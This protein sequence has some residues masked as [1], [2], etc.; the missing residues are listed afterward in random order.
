LTLSSDLIDIDEKSV[1]EDSMKRFSLVLWAALLF[2]TTSTAFA[3]PGLSVY[4]VVN[5]QEAQLFADLFKKETGIEVQF[6]RAATGDLLN[7]VAAEKSAP[8]ADILLGG[9]STLHLGLAAKGVLAVYKSPVAAT[10]PDYAQDPDGHWTGFYITTLGIGVNETRFKQKFGNTP[11]PK[12][13]DDLVNP[14]FKGEIVLTDP[15]ASSTAYLFVQTQLQRLGWD[16]GWAYLGKLAPLVGQFPSSGGAPPQLVGS[17]EYSIGVA[18]V[19]ALADYKA[20]GFPIQLI[21]PPK[22]SGEI[23]AVSIIAGGP[24][25]ANA[26]KF[27]DFVLS[28]AAQQAFVNLSLTTPLNPAVSAPSTGVNSKTL[29]LQKFDAALAATQR[30]AVLA[31]WQ[32]VVK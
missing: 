8:Q 20:K 13:W 28:P 19:H 29:D 32:K 14:A 7:R 9:A 25:P 26:K 27:V 5:Q 16:A 10:L 15:A 31:Q 6:L 4:A 12:T 23:G 11:V 24:N 3:A 22:T 21:V 30:D 17:G 18:F 2:S 1:K